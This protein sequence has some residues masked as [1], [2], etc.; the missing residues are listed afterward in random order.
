MRRN[1]RVQTRRND[2]EACVEANQTK[3]RKRTRRI[4]HGE[5]QLTKNTHTLVAKHSA[6]A[7]ADAQTRGRFQ[8]AGRRG[9]P[10]SRDA[11]EC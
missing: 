6:T 2:R 5:S 4:A 11:G 10:G 3:R 1:E 7:Y 9:R 8:R